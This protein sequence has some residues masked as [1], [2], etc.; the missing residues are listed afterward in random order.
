MRILAL[1]GESRRRTVP[2]HE[3][4]GERREMAQQIVTEEAVLPWCGGWLIEAD[5][6]VLSEGDG[7]ACELR[8]NEGLVSLRL[9]L[10]RA[11]E[12]TWRPG[13]PDEDSVKVV[14]L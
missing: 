4:Y 14:S 13:S 2:L 3:H 1:K 11:L 10:P 9:S 7:F 6:K 12:L 5:P 8:M